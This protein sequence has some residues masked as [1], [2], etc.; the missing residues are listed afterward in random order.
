MNA[1]ELIKIFGD[2]KRTRASIITDVLPNTRYPFGLIGI[3]QIR[4]RDKYIRLFTNIF[5]SDRTYTCK[6]MLAKVVNE[7]II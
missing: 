7:L 5:A 3:T 2:G 4:T 1:Y 6:E